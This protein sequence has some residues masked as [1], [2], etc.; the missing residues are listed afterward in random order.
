[1]NADYAA[2][3]GQLEV[4]RQSDKPF[5]G[6]PVNWTAA[7]RL[8]V[9]AECC[10]DR[11][12]LVQVMNTCPPSV[13]TGQAGFTPTAPAL[14]GD[15]ERLQWQGLTQDRGGTGVVLLSQFE[16]VIPT[17]MVQHVWCRHRRWAVPVA[18]IV[19]GHGRHVLPHSDKP[20]KSR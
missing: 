12:P 3:L 4:L 7:R 13:V 2:V 5:G 15:E 16:S 1:M 17:R 19:N 14:T 11:E 18:V 20:G 6:E 8:A 10:P 9:V